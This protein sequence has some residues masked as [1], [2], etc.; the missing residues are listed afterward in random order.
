MN[1][2]AA[3]IGLGLLS[4]FVIIHL[5][6]YGRA[7][8]HPPVTGEP[9]WDSPETKALFHRTCADCHS[10]E[11]KWPWYASIA[12]FSWMVTRHV[13]EGRE[14]FNVSAWGQQKR[15]EGEEAAEEF[16]EGEMPLRAYTLAHPEAALSEEEAKQLIA[17][18]KATFGEEGEEHHDEPGDGPAED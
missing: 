5:V 14:H 10:H 17:G 11:T 8:E 12:P 6:P 1:S 16:E 4:L 13:T 3:K 7:H 18:L 2:P 9:A 15:N